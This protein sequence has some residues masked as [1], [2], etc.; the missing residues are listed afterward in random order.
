MDFFTLSVKEEHTFAVCSTR[1]CVTLSRQSR[2]SN[3]TG[4]K[5]TLTQVNCIRG[6]NALNQTDLLG[7]Q[8][9]TVVSYGLLPIL[10]CPAHVLIII[11]FPCNKFAF[12]EIKI[13][14]QV[15]F[16]LLPKLKICYDSQALHVFG[17][18]SVLGTTV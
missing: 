13:R 15:S 6:S 12:L 1:V 17:E 14:K 16:D 10:N 9:A 5:F 3:R 11:A 2:K 8:G 7:S 18:C 4:N